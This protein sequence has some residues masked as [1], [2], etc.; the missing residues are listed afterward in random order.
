MDALERDAFAVLEMEA[1][2]HRFERKSFPLLSLGHLYRLLKMVA[3]AS[4]HRTWNVLGSARFC[5]ETRKRKNN[6]S[7]G[8]LAQEAEG[9][10]MPRNGESTNSWRLQNHLLR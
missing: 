7:L 8:L 6:Q 10:G 3:C 9:Q 5:S 1:G 4:K 2:R